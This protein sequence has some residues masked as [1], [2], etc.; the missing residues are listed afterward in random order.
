MDG[1]EQGADGSLT[2]HAI[3]CKGH[4]SLVMSTVTSGEFVSLH[5]TLAARRVPKCQKI[6]R[7]LS[8]IRTRCPVA[9]CVGLPLVDLH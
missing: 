1:H 9:E 6:C 8:P 3:E 4:L 5:A 7:Y 2:L